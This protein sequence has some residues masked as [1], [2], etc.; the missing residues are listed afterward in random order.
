METQLV[1]VLDAIQDLPEFSAADVQAETGLPRK[2][3]A[4][5]ITELKRRKEVEDIGRVVFNYD[6]GRPAKLFRMVRL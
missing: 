5:Y 1:R 4:A 3:V 2:H 6:R